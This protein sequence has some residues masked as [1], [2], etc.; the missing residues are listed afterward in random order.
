MF[1]T[2]NATYA[3]I[4]AFL[5]W[6]DAEIGT[7]TETDEVSLGVWSATCFELEGNEKRRCE[8][9]WQNN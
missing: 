7:E 8:A 6:F 9:W 4:A 5:R 2:P 1:T 3:R